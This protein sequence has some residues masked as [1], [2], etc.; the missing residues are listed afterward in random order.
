[1][2]ILSNRSLNKPSPAARKKPKTKRVV[3]FTDEINKYK[4]DKDI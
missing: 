4:T 2:S 1:M 3:I